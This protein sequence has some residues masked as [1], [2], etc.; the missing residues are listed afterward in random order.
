M[1]TN[2]IE[3]YRTKV[4]PDLKRKHERVV[5]ALVDL[6]GSATVYEIADRLNTAVHN[7]SGRLTELSGS[8]YERPVIKADGR[9]TNKYGNPCT[10]W[11]LIVRIEG[12]QQI[13]F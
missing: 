4:L 6:G 3:I 2:S 1:N 10:V 8:E 13:L 11:S 7:I 9:R 5:G 12:K